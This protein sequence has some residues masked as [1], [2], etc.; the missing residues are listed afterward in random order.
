[1]IGAGQ[2]PQPLTPA[3]PEPSVDLCSFNGDKGTRG[4]HNSARHF[5]SSLPCLL[6]SDFFLSVNKKALRAQALEALVVRA[7][8][9]SLDREQLERGWEG[10]PE[11][12]RPWREGNEPGSLVAAQG[13]EGGFAITADARVYIPDIPGK[14]GILR[15]CPGWEDE[16]EGIKLLLFS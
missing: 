4:E 16:Q 2:S 12:I 9:L 10:I 3:G 5:C 11:Q 15:S 6:K 1:M 7:S 14:P 8:S 13:L